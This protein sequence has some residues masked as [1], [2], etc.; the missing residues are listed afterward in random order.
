MHKTGP[1]LSQLPPKLKDNI[2]DRIQLILNSNFLESLGIFWINDSV[3][4]GIFNNLN[5]YTKEGILTALEKIQNQGGEEGND[6]SK[7]FSL[8]KE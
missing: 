1:C 4:Q 2:L 7:L 6:A 8:L 3:Q 5:K